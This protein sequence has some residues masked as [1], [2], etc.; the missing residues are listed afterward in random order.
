MSATADATGLDSITFVV[1]NVTMAGRNVTLGDDEIL[2][3][4][5]DDVKQYA[6]DATTAT[7]DDITVYNYTVSLADTLSGNASPAFVDVVL[8]YTIS[9]TAVAGT[10]YTDVTGGAVTILAGESSATVSIQVLRVGEATPPTVILTLA[11]AP[12]AG[13]AEILGVGDDNALTVTIE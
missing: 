7:V 9:G 1:S 8:N 6:F 13:D 2:V 3:E 11:A 12:G 4:V 5:Q 10:D